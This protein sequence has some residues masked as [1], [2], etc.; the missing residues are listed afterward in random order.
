MKDDKKNER[1]NRIINLKNDL[2][3][4]MEYIGLSE[5]MQDLKI[6]KVWNECVGDTI[7]K[8]SK[9]VEIK[10]NK[11]YVSV[12]NAVWRYELSARKTEILE[13]VNQILKNKIIKDIIFV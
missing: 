7:S 12:E 4:F 9:P 3:E 1:G 8:F 5:K 13:R 11:L 10:K 2:D 6:L